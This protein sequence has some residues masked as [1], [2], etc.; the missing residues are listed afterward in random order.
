[1][2]LRPVLAKV[3]LFAIGL[4]GV[5]TLAGCLDPAASAGSQ[6]A[7]GDGPQTPAPTRFPAALAGGACQL[8][9]YTVIKTAIAIDFDVAAASESAGTASCV[10]ESVGASLPDLTLSVTPSKISADVFASTVMP[11]GATA[12]GGLGKRAYWVP[13]VAAGTAGPGIEVGWLSGNQR[14]MLLRLRSAAGTQAAEVA[15]LAPRLVALAK[16]IDKATS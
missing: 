5:G 14:L 12:A 10:L 7:S 13:V 2:R 6:A 9:D 3:A 16:T 8:L 1:M 11:K 4:T 15:P